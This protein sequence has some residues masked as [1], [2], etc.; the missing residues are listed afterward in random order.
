MNYCC[1]QEMLCVEN[2]GQRVCTVC[3]ITY[4]LPSHCANSPLDSPRF[5]KPFVYKRVQ[6]FVNWLKRIQAQD[7]RRIPPEILEL[8]DKT[9]TAEEIRKILKK[10]GFAKYYGFI[11]SIILA[12]NGQQPP[13]LPM[14]VEKDLIEDFRAVEITFLI[15]KSTNRKN[16]LPYSYILYKL[17]QKNEIQ[18]NFGIRISSNPHTIASYDIIWQRICDLLRWKFVPTTSFLQ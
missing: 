17:L 10:N 7:T 14:T 13:S 11:P 1:G 6:H 5:I 12:V 16:M 9:H 2:E 3:G 8:C 4:C 18:I 15:V